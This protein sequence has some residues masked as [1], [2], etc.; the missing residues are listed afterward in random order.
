MFNITGGHLQETTR[1]GN[2]GAQPI[3]MT[4]NPCRQYEGNQ[5]LRFQDRRRSGSHY[6][7]YRR[8]DQVE[9]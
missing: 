8:S 9:I 1:S 2:A 7:I 3:C 6:I 5:P 4:I